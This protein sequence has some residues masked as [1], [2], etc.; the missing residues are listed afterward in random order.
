MHKS[1]LIANILRLEE[2]SSTREAHAGML[3]K[4]K[5]DL[6]LLKAPLEDL[7]V[8]LARHVQSI[9]PSMA[10][11]AFDP[12]PLLTISAVRVKHYLNDCSIVFQGS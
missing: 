10:A 4:M 1:S 12:E 6:S 9:V 2:A 3:E 7:S 5:G 8:S 11:A